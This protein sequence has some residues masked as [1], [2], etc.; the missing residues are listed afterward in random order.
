MNIITDCAN[1][2]P[3]T[4][5][6]T[7]YPLQSKLLTVYPAIACHSVHMYVIC[8]VVYI[9]SYIILLLHCSVLTVIYAQMHAQI[10]IMLETLVKVK[11]VAS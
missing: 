2:A 8:N 1:N 3:L 11:N 10:I 9:Y 7:V 5:L 6:V 4:L